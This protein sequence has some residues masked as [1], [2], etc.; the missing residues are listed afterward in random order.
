MTSAPSARN[1]SQHLA[2]HLRPVVIGGDILAY[3]YVREFHRAYGIE[4][5]IVLATQDIKMLSKSRFTDY[6]LVEGVTSRA[7]VLYPALEALAR[8]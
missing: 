7:D 4:R 8:A 3:S 5:T 6:R 2:D 1:T